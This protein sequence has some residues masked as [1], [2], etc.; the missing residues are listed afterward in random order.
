MAS[1]CVVKIKDDKGERE[2]DMEGRERNTRYAETFANHP[3]MK[4]SLR[5]RRERGETEA[6]YRIERIMRVLNRRVETTESSCTFLF[7]SRSY[8]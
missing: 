7:L 5:R 6:N 8:V 4:P 2:R 3:A 1:P